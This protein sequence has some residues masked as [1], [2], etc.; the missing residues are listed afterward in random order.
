MGNLFTKKNRVH[1]GLYY[2]L[3]FKILITETKDRSPLEDHIKTKVEEHMLKYLKEIY[4]REFNEVSIT[5]LSL[6]KDVYYGEVKWASNKVNIIDLN[7]K[8]NLLF[9]TS[10]YILNDENWK[11]VC[12]IYTI[13]DVTSRK[14]FGYLR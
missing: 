3:N 1:A 11:G 7:T 10:T 12:Y 5:I 13:S 8:L 6:Y 14:A 2:T 4:N 9:P